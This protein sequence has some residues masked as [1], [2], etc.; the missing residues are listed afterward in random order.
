M[1]H[2]G[3]DTKL[4]LEVARH[5]VLAL[6][7][8]HDGHD[9]GVALRPLGDD[10]VVAGVQHPV[11]RLLAHPLA[12]LLLALQRVLLAQ[13]LALL[14]PDLAPLLL[15]VPQLGL[16]P[17]VHHRSAHLA[18][19]PHVARARQLLHL[20]GDARFLGRQ[21]RLQRHQLLLQ[22]PRLVPRLD[23]V[24]VHPCRAALVADGP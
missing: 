10:G 12:V 23:Q 6:V 2:G 16:R 5:A 17:L 13:Q 22:L 8:V 15:D 3:V 21:L 9:V 11:P 7:A 20:L 4:L 19:G 1:R 14:V 24:P 18:V